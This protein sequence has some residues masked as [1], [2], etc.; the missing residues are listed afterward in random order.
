MPSNTQNSLKHLYSEACTQLDDYI[1]FR[2]TQR[3]AELKPALDAKG[4]SP[5][6][7][8]IGAPTL[9]PPEALIHYTVKCLKEP[10]IHL[11]SIPKGEGF[12]R[13]AVARWMQRRF[14]VET[15]PHTE[16]C[17]LIGSKEGLGNLF[18]ALITP[19]ADPKQ[20][21]IFL[22]P[23]PGYANYKAAIETAGGL[24]YPTPLLPE[25]GFL[26]DLDQTLTRLQA[27]G[28]DPTQL[29]AL[30]VNYPSNPTGAMATL[31]FYQ[32]AVDFCRTHQI[33]LISD[34]A[35][36]D[37]YFEDPPRSV[38]EVPGA[39][40]VAIELFSMSKPYAMTGWRV[41]FAVGHPDLVDVLIRMKGTLDSGVFRGFQKAA[42]FALESPEC[43]S[44][45]GQANRRY[46]ENQKIMLKGL[47]E[48]GWPIEE[49]HIPKA[50][51]YLW[52]P[53]PPRYATSTAFTEDLL[54][55][56]GII[57]V[58]G[59]AFGRHGE[60]HIRLALTL[61]PG[62]MQEAI[63]RMQVDGFRY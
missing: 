61:A 59:T 25:K 27:D 60:G 9:E 35:Y 1:M 53:I 8:S 45:A 56:S 52:I 29:K 22:T 39:K 47:Q 37:I 15:D 32:E 4:R 20:R 33:A 50:T 18:R 14:N 11:Y 5:L 31:D 38:L 17:A 54:K 24:S 23:D 42:A 30:I 10:G 44:Y 48:L 28:Y 40:D 36:V 7:L 3:A 34:A 26:P 21:D 13:E 41:G 55:T 6:R 63:H 16:V 12:F 57:T 58:P 49:M 43:Q 19:Q 46:L 51:F 2:I 62:D